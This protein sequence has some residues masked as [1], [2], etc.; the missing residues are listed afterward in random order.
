[1]ILMTSSVT[2]RSV[3]D[4]AGPKWDIVGDCFLARKLRSLVAMTQLDK[5][6]SWI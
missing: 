6:A 3:S 5:E 1:M 4:E 2:A